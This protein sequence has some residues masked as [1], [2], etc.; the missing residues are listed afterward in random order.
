MSENTFCLPNSFLTQLGE[1]TNGYVLVTVNENGEFESFV[2]TPTPVVKLALGKFIG[3]LAATL[4]GAT[5]ESFSDI[6]LDN[7]MDSGEET[8]IA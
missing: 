2:N 5:E 1:F 8:A 6:M 4:E 3:M 7:E